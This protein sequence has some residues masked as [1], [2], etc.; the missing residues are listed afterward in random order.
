[1]I[2]G[3]VLNGAIAQGAHDYLGRYHQSDFRYRKAAAKSCS[4]GLRRSR[5][6]TRLRVRP[7][8][9]SW[10]TNSSSSQQPSTAA[11]AMVPIGTYERVMPLDI[12]PTLLLRDL[13]V[14]DTDNAQALELLGWTKT[15]ALCGFVPGKLNT[16]RCCAVLE[17]IEGRLIMGL[18]HF[19]EKSNRTSCRAANMKNGMPSMKLRRRF[20]HHIRRGNAQATH[21]RALD[22]SA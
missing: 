6:N 22:S 18:K 16:A 9:I 12:L 13:I 5:T 7:S 8:V 4:A 2:S 19:L 11:T 17:T 1:M 10:K 21:V 3:S 20:S 15:L 14:G